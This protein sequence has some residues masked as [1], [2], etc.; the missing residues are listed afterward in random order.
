MPSFAAYMRRAKQMDA[1]RNEL[2]NAPAK[3]V[4]GWRE[5]AAANPK[6][7][8]QLTELMH[9][10]TIVGIDPSKPFEPIRDNVQFDPRN[11]RFQNEDLATGEY[12]TPEYVNKRIKELKAQAKER[13]GDG[14]AKFME[15]IKYLKMRLA[16]QRNR[17]DAQERISEVWDKLSPEGQK[18]YEDVRDSYSKQHKEYRKALEERIEDEIADERHREAFKDVIRKIFETQQVEGP[19]FPLARFGDFFGVIKDA[20]DNV[21]E[22]SKFETKDQRR[23][24]AEERQALLNEGEIIKLGK[25]SD[26]SANAMQQVDP[27]Y[28]NEVMQTLDMNKVNGPLM[29][30]INQIYLNRL[31]A[32]S[33]RKQFIHRKKT[34]GFNPDAMRAYSHNMFHGAYQLA[35]LRHSH[36]MQ[37]YLDDM[38]KEAAIATDTDKAKDIYNEMVKRHNWAMNPTSSPW[39][40]KATS[41]GFAWYLGVTPAAAFVNTTQ[42][43]MVGL[44]VLGSRYGFVE[45]AKAL[46]QA[47]MD[48]IKGGFHVDKALTDPKERAA[49]KEFERR[50]LIDKTLAHDLA[51]VSEGGLNYSST[52]HKVMGYI[53]FFFHHAERY[54]REVT[55]MAAFRL[56]RK[57]GEAE[58]LEVAEELTLDSHFDYSNAER[59][60]FM[61]NDAAKVLLLFRQHSLN[62]TYRLLRDTNNAMR[63]ESAEVKRQARRQLTGILGMTGLFAGTAGLPFMYF[64]A[65]I[66]GS[67]IMGDEDEPWEFEV[68]FRKY[69]ADHIGE[70]AAHAVVHGVADVATGANISSRIGMNNLWFREA[71]PTLEG[72]GLVQY[73]AE[74][75]LGPIA[76]MAFSAGTAWDIGRKGQLLRGMEYAL[77]KALKD[78][79]RG[80]RYID[81]GVTNIRGDALINDT[82]GLEEFYQIMGF[83]PTRIS[84]TYEQ[85]SAIKSYEKSI[86]YRR[87]LLINQYATAKRTGDKK[88]L[89]GIKREIEK[90]NKTQPDVQISRKTLL[91]SM[92]TRQRYSDKA[93]RGIQI[94]DRLQEKL[95]RLNFISE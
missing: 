70:T 78:S 62:M 85:N 61:Q 69:L 91:R 37:A 58:P 53:S 93:Q 44:P 4:D 24:W 19:Y 64:G 40:A 87:Q 63:G 21:V 6:E 26:N 80:L 83:T 66:I 86:L 75:A 94:D 68:E 54:N 1:D 8:R 71:D 92:R 95:S 23:K 13:S 45:S 65:D 90:F 2:M 41:L 25:L 82:S 73:Y 28:H 55:A 30:E 38:D 43:W 56:A 15:R 50:G 81:E 89:Q 74:Q 77:P 79:L 17:E 84:E 11:I 35:R 60:R 27:K 49:F 7:A 59:A 57:A 48:F 36:K 42:T 5:Y 39:A 76:G 18:L 32:S 51:G 67:A 3:V 14:T 46:L 52:M 47:S 72:R 10:T 34:A 9:E 22:F 88:Y 16:Q 31:P 29:D 12:I 20:N 33:M